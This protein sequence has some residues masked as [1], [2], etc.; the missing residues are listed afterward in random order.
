MASGPEGTGF[1]ATDAPVA[2]RKAKVELIDE[3]DVG[4][5]GKKKKQPPRESSK[6]RA[7]GGGAAETAAE[8]R[9][10]AA[11]AAGLRPPDLN[12]PVP[13]PGS[14]TDGE[15]MCA[16]PPCC[17]KKRVGNMYVC[18]ER[19]VKGTPRILC[20][21]PACWAMQCFTQ[22]LVWGVGAP[23]FYFSFPSH[24]PWCALCLSSDFAE[25]LLGDAH[26]SHWRHRA[27][28][29][30]WVVGSMLLVVTSL[31]LF[32]VGTS[33]PGILP[34]YRAPREECAD[35][36]S[37]LIPLLCRRCHCAKANPCSACFAVS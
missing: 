12:Y 7:P 32:R 1:G 26:H 34:L 10:G 28:G 37:S 19:Q 24:D 16:P 4:C 29:R 18:C 20:G 21:W 13:P 35:L 17:Y 14:M 8:T 11:E 33:D 9:P 36:M 27:W 25:D 2:P 15:C 23:V 3:D 30:V 31:S 6:R 5:T 22:A